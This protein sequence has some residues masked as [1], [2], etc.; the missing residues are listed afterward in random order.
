MNQE[1]IYCHLFTGTPT[2]EAVL[3]GFDTVETFEEDNHMSRRLVKCRQCPQL[4]FY[5]FDEEVDFKG[6]EDPQF[7]TWIPVTSPEEAHQ[8]NSQSR[9]QFAKFSPRLE[10][11]WPS[12]QESPTVEWR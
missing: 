4:Y 3:N 10:Y 11:S 9:M 6:G 12:D 1:T 8:L 5:A 7:R 2:R